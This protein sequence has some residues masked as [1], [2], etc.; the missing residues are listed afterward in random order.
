VIQKL[1][2]KRAHN[3][4][5]KFVISENNEW[6]MA[7]EN[8]RLNVVVRSCCGEIMLWWDHASQLSEVKISENNSSNAITYKNLNFLSVW[9]NWVCCTLRRRRTPVSENVLLT[10]VCLFY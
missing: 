3:I 10:I 9:P 4:F 1:T 8:R 6:R 2:R 5:L 7:K